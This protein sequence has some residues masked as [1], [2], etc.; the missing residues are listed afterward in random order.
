MSIGG[1]EMKYVISLLNDLQAKP[2]NLTTSGK[3]T[4]TNGAIYLIALVLVPL[5][6]AGVFPRSLLA[7]AFLYVTL[8]MRAWSIIGRSTDSKARHA[9]PL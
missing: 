9:W 1:D 2:T 7:F 3:C 6:L 8:G 5:A 4:E